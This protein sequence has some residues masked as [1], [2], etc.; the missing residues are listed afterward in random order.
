M[1]WKNRTFLLLMTGEVVAGAGIWIFILANLQ[2]MQ[3]LIPSDTLKAFVL[4]S[5]LAVSILLSPKAGV[6]IDTYDKRKVLII[7]SWVRCISPVLMLPAIAYDSLIWMIIAL[8]VMQSSAAFY[9][10]TLQS[11]LPAILTKDELLK[12]NSAYLNISTLSRIFGTAAGGILVAAFSLSQLYLFSLVAYVVL[13]GITFFV[14]IPHV[15]QSQQ[16]EKIEFREVLTAS[17]KDPAIFVGLINSGLITLF[18]GGVN[19]MILN[20]SSIQG[21]PQLMGW[22][23]AAEGISILIGGLLAKRWIGG[24]NLVSSSTLMLFFFAVSQF[25]MTFVD[26][27]VMVLA[28]FAFFGFIVAFFFPVTTTIFQKRLPQNQHGRFFSFKSMLDRSFF[29]LALAITG[30]SLDLLGLSL[31]LI[32]LATVTLFA[33]IFTYMYS[34]KHKLDVR[35]S[36]ESPAAA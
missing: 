14:Q 30:A 8:I 4:M 20:F 22:I 3:G 9:F 32:C 21:E 25:G 6:I 19:L 23:F 10:P 11:S 16:R 5:G 7:S 27:K 26:N 17:R 35:S 34:K 36:D 2:F 12:A 13:A 28:S 1:L 31:Y 33:G 24:R 15:Q 29:F 18:L